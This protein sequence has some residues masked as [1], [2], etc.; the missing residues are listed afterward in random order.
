MK[1][2]ALYRLVLFGG[3]VLIF[4]IILIYRHLSKPTDN[5]PNVIILTFLG[6]RNE[7]TID[8]PTHQYIPNI[9]NKLKPEGTLYTNLIVKDCEF[10]MP[11]IQAINTGED[12]EATWAIFKPTFFHYVKQQHRLP[13]YKLWMINA[14]F[15]SSSS[16][17]SSSNF[18]DMNEPSAFTALQPDQDHKN[19]KLW[20]IFSDQEKEFNFRKR[21]GIEYRVTKWPVWDSMENIYYGVLQKILQTYKPKLVHYLLGGPECAHYGNYARYVL[22]IK[23]ADEEVA[24]VW[25]YIKENPYYRD[26]TFL[27]ITVDHSRDLYYAHHNK[28]YD[29]VWLYVFGP[30]IKKDAVINRPIYHVDIFS[31]LAHLMNIKT[32]KANGKVLS[33]CFVK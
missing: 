21:Q 6:V 8:E 11:S 15:K 17:V 33:D 4:C 32:H 7:E 10:H 20:E 14:W 26:S 3:V 1:R 9:W 28:M 16:L 12:Y 31:T 23:N 22:S 27:F 13:Q 5:L 2:I 25:Q 24:W 30:G 19:R 18:F 29:P